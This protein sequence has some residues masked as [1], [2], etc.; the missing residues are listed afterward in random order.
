[1]CTTLHTSKNDLHTFLGDVS[2]GVLILVFFATPF[3]ASRFNTNRLGAAFVSICLICG[4][5][6]LIGLKLSNPFSLWHSHKGSDTGGSRFFVPLVPQAILHI[7][8]AVP[9]RSSK[10]PMKPLEA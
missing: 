4:T 6:V 3:N 1:M 7:A 5:Y 2:F 9:R 8:R 10:F